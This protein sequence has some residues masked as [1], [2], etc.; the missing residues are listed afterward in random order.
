MQKVSHI[1]TV[2]KPSGVMGESPTAGRRTL[3][4]L[5]TKVVK[6]ERLDEWI[7]KKSSFPWVHI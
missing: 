2:N 6:C 4:D 3:Q 5:M 7:S 1:A